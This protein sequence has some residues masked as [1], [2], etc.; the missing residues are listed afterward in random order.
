MYPSALRLQ[1]GVCSLLI[2]LAVGRAKGDCTRSTQTDICVSL[3]PHSNILRSLP[4][5]RQVRNHEQ[6]TFHLSNVSPLEQCKLTGTAV[7]PAPPASA[8]QGAD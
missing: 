7:T 2:V 3:D 5:A 1:V 4:S 6:V 8:L